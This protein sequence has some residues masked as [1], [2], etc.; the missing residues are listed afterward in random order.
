MNKEATAEE[1]IA[2]G[3]DN[4]CLA[5]GSRAFIPPIPGVDGANV[6][7]ADDAITGAPL[8]GN[9][10]VIGAG[11]VGCEAALHASKTASHVEVIEM[12]PKIL[13][14][15]DHLFNLD[16]WLHDEMDKFVAAGNNEIGRAHV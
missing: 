5:A 6:I 16:Q 1:V 4:V 3:F 13:A 8:T 2:A 7:A 14:Q 11:L 9:V 12:L 15:A 10:V